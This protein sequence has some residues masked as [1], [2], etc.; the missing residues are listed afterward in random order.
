MNTSIRSKKDTSSTLLIGNLVVVF[1]LQFVML[2]IFAK[3]PDSL[4][5]T[6]KLS[7]KEVIVQFNIGRDHYSNKE[8]A[9]AYKLWLLAADANILEAYNN[10]GYLNY[11]G[12]GVE[13]NREEG[14]R[15][16]RIAAVNGLAESQIHLSE[17]YS[18]GVILQ[19]DLIEAYAWAKAAAYFTP[20]E[21]DDDLRKIYER[22]SKKLIVEYSKT[23]SK[24]AL[25][26]AKNR[27]R[28]LI[29]TISETLKS[30]Q[31]IRL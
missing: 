28:S 8:Y 27:A 23:L 31:Y 24:N 5:N 29:S 16:W 10:L 12:L 14:V 30:T 3:K 6:A 17:V 15:L 25:N 26:Q 9:E 13:Q 19:K 20:Q 18:D 11:N 22:D 21:S 1:V 2:F 4:V 7:L